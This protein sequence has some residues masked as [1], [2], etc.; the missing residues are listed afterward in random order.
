MNIMMPEQEAMALA[1]EYS[2]AECILEFGSGGSTALASRM[3][4]KVFSVESDRA[5]ADRI[6]KETSAVVH[7]VDIGPTKGHGHPKD[8]S[9][10]HKWPD[11]PISVWE[12]ADFVEP[13]LILIDGRFRVACFLVALLKIK[14]ETLILF[15]DFERE[16]Y[17]IVKNFFKPKQEKRLAIFEVKPNKFDFSKLSVLSK[18]FFQT[19]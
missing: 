18:S 12:R 2:K 19:I 9:M 17:K 10:Q 7:H 13:D 3:G 14:R 1:E 6:A 11:Y 15:D 4:K 5:W 16:Q 8:R